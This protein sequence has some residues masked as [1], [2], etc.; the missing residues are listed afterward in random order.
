MRRFRIGIFLKN[1]E[2]GDYGEVYGNRLIK[3]YY[4]LL[5]KTLFK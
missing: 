1:R 5:L 3:I 2:E 4:T